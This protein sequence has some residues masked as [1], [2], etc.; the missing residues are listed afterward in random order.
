MNREEFLEK[1]N[2]LHPRLLWELDGPKREGEKEPIFKLS[3]YNING[4]VIIHQEWPEGRGG[5]HYFPSL[6]NTYDAT[7]EQVLGT[8]KLCD[9]PPYEPY[10]PYFSSDSTHDDTREISKKPTQE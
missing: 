5:A 3:G 10:D 9:T 6:H 4:A 2:A 7:W 8:A 1:W